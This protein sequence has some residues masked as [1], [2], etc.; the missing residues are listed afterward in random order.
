[1]KRKT[2]T[3][4]R[5]NEREAN[6]YA[7]RCMRVMSLVALAAWLLNIIGFFIVPPKAKNAGMSLCIFFF[8][9]PSAICRWV[10]AEKTG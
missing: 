3:I 8:L 2:A 1:M 6:L 7:A 10:S 5:E 9:V 4:F